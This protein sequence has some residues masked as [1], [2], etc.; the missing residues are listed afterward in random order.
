MLRFDLA[1]TISILA[2]VARKKGEAA[3]RRLRPS[4]PPSLA[5]SPPLAA[6][7]KPYQPGSMTR[8]WDQENTH[9]MARRSAMRLEAVREAGREP[10]FRSAISLTGVDWRK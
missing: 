7:P 3:C 5:R 10:I 8:D 9:G 6:A 4:R 1:S 2:T